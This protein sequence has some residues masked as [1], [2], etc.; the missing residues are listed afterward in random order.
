MNR[1]EEAMAHCAPPAELEERLRQKVLAAPPAGSHV[2]RHWSLARKAA[3]AAVLTLALTV[4][5]GAALLEQ[6][7]AL[8]EK[9]RTVLHLHYCEGYSQQEIA[10]LLGITVSAVKMRMKRG[11]EALRSSW[12][13]AE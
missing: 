7:A 4:S 12:E 1:Y 11:R 8:P 2:L 9:L 3:L 13:G 10:S 6:V 5:V